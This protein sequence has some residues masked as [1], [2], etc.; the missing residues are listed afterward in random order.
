ML[1]KNL[2]F[3]EQLPSLNKI[4]NNKYIYDESTYINTKTKMR[5]I[6][7][8]H[9]DFYQ[10]ISNHKRG[11]GCPKCRCVK[12]RQKNTLSYENI[13]KEYR[14]T[15]GDKYDYDPTTYINTKI[16]M[17]IICPLHGEFW[18][19]PNNHK[20]GQGCPKCAK[21][22]TK[23]IRSIDELITEFN[24]IHNN[25]Y[26]YDSTTYKNMHSKMKIICAIHGEFWQT[27][28]N[29]KNNHGCMICA[30]EERAKNHKIKFNDFIKY[31]NKI[32]NNKYTYKKSSYTNASSKIS[33]ICP[34]HGEFSQL[35]INHYRGQGCPRCNRSQGELKIINTLNNFNIKFIEEKKFKDCKYKS[36]LPFD[37]YLPEL[38]ICIEYDGKQHYEFVEHFHRTIEEFYLRQLLDKIKNNYCFVKKIKL[39]RIP[40]WK[41]N[42]IDDIITSCLNIY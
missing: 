22:K 8:I 9:G 27:P 21:F 12:I 16:K 11:D 6:C 26:K 36:Y 23:K 38:D 24:F 42:E 30:I 29:H 13:L 40:Y 17:K 5:I 18:Q 35:A 2:T 1:N 19:S 32:H 33:I 4:H 37:F 41:I 34:I 10:T 25:K 14:I 20:K 3:Q 15:H 28:S 7:P 31:S 39:I